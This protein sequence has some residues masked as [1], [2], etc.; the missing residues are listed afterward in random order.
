MYTPVYTSIYIRRK[1]YEIDHAN[2]RLKLRKKWRH[3]G[4]PISNILT[5][6]LICQLILRDRFFSARLTVHLHFSHPNV[7]SRNREKWLFIVVSL[8]PDDRPIPTDFM[9]RYTRSIRL[10]FETRSRFPNRLVGAMV[11]LD[12]SDCCAETYDLSRVR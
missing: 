5:R 11:K 10:S 9:N 12:V 1:N 6:V 3:Y 7:A 4:D 2:Q 8:V